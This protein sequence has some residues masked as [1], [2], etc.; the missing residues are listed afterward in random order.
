MPAAES[1][2]AT[3]APAEQGYQAVRDALAE[4]GLKVHNGPR[5]AEAIND[6]LKQTVDFDLEGFKDKERNYTDELTTIDEERA[7]A[8]RNIE[9]WTATLTRLDARRKDVVGHLRAARAARRELEDEM[10]GE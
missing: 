2:R 5:P 7:E 8:Q 9:A 10:L 4:R 1:T 3:A 6:A